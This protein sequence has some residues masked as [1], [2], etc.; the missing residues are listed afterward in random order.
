MTPLT[1]PAKKNWPDGQ[2]EQG[3]GVVLHVQ[4]ELVSQAWSGVLQKFKN[5]KPL[6]WNTLSMGQAPRTVAPLEGK[7]QPDGVVKCH[8]IFFSLIFSKIP[9]LKPEIDFFRN[10]KGLNH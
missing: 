5:L 2:Q 4:E 3:H 9:Y 6:E 10:S 7:P 1:H 8:S